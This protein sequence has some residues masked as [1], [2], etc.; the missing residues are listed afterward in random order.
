[1]HNLKTTYK[2]YCGLE[3]NNMLHWLCQEKKCFYQIFQCI[4][5]IQFDNTE[6]QDYY[7]TQLLQR[8]CWWGCMWQLGENGGQGKPLFR[9]S[10]AR[11]YSEFLL[12]AEKHAVLKGS[13]SLQE[14]AKKVFSNDNKGELFLLVSTLMVHAMVLPVSTTD[15]ELFQYDELG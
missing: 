3:T 11:E 8:Q 2:A 10:R 5:V 4:A 1:M 13:T 15:W 12:F 6:T 9:R 14:L 7:K